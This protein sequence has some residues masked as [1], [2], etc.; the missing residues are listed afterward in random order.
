MSSDFRNVLKKTG[1]RETVAGASVEA[2]PPPAVNA[3]KEITKKQAQIQFRVSVL[4][5]G[6]ML[7][8]FDK[9]IQYFTFLHF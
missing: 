7:W 2:D 3:P 9:Q 4:Q 8:M 1:L 6:C 5:C